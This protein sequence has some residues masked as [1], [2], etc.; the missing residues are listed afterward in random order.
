MFKN[1]YTPETELSPVAIKLWEQFANIPINDQDEIEESFLHFEEGT[2]RE[3]V[4][5]WFEETY[6]C[7]VAVDLQHIEI[8]CD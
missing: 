6:D 4:W 1:N 5:H 2:E 3:E 8:H 7:S